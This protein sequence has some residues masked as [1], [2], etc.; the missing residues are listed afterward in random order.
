MKQIEEKQ[1]YQQFFDMV[2]RICFLYMK[3]E[4]DAYDMT[5]ETFLR[6]LKNKP[7]FD[8]EEKA[9]AWLIVTASNCCRTQLSKWWRSR[10]EVYDEELLMAAAPEKTEREDEIREL[11]WSLDKKYSVPLY[12]YYFEGYKIHEISVM[13][14]IKESTIQTRLA[15]ARTFLRLELEQSRN[16]EGNEY[17]IK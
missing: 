1:L 17:E 5:Q 8:S 16:M 13:L 10:R 14:K 15:R 3:Q 9:K 2:Y 4:S 12:L 11:V 7:S 6:L